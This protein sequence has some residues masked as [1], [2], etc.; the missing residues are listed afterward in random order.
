MYIMAGEKE[1]G[2]MV[3]NAK[4]MEEILKNNYPN[5]EVNLKI[6]VGGEHNEGTWSKEFPDALHWLMK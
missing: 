2:N 6:A 1:E 3:E 4:K 5:L